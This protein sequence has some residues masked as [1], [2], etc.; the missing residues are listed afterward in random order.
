MYSFGV[1]INTMTVANGI[2]LHNL[3]ITGNSWYDGKVTIAGSG[4]ISTAG[5]TVS[6]L[7]TGVTGARAHVTNAVACTFG[8]TPVNGCTTFC[9]VIYN[10]SAWI[11][12]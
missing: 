2:D 11:A 5:F 10:G 12:G 4:T 8:S 9:P 1:E 3:T 7:P 6:G